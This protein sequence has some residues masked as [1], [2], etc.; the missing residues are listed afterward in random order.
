MS[1]SACAADERP[2][3]AAAA[4]PAKL[5]LLRNLEDV[6]D[7]GE[8]RRGEVRAASVERIVSPRSSSP[9]DYR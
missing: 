5:A 2:R 1:T 4:S 3:N 7:C 9:H 8:I 6:F